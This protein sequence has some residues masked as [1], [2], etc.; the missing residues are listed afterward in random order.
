[1]FAESVLPIVSAMVAGGRRH[2]VQGDN[3]DMD[4]RMN[5]RSVEELD[6]EQDP[7]PAI[8]G[9]RFLEEEAAEIH[10]VVGC[11][12]ATGTFTGTG[13]DDHDQVVIA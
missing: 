3:R 7:M 5:L 11:L 6:D 13:C 2:N 8:F 1:M 12:I 4:T 10:D 9:L